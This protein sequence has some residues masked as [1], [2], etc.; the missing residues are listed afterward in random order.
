MK[1]KIN[2]LLTCIRKQIMNKGFFCPSCGSKKSVIVSRKYFVTTLNR[3]EN[4]KL[5]FRLPVTTSEENSSFYQEEYSQGFTTDCPTESLLKNLV[6]NKF[7]GGE[8]DY[9]EYIKVIK[10]AGGDRGNRLFDFGCSWG[11]GSW[12]FMQKG[13]DVES[14]EISKSRAN[15]ARNKLGVKVHSSL[16]GVTGLFDIFFSSHVI[17]HVPSVKDAIDFG[18]SILKPGG[19]FVAFTPN[20]SFDFYEKDSNAWNKLWGQ[21]HPNFLDDEYYMETFRGKQLLIS[22]NPYQIKKIEEWDRNSINEVLALEVDGHELLILV[23]K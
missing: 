18:M 16:S 7:L 11:Y 2:Y 22:S 20:G 23:K 19:L 12:Q 3:C 15:Y 17:E 21:V 5:L 1:Q 14:F 8:K 6:K 9:S 13:F 10:A 4:C